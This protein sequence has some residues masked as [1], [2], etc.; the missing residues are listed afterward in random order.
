MEVAVVAVS[1]WRKASASGSN[2]CV[3]V[4]VV[5]GV[6]V[7]MRN[8]RD[9]EGSVLKFTPAEWDAFVNGVQAGEFQQG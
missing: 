7:F 8:S 2:G 5:P 1:E 3:E 4:K 6:A 9:L